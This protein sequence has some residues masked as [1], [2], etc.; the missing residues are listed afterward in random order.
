M[1]A[2]KTSRDWRT[3][4]DYLG[5]VKSGVHEDFQVSNVGEIG[6]PPPADN[7]DDDEI[8]SDDEEDERDEE[9]GESGDGKEGRRSRGTR[10]VI[11]FENDTYTETNEQQA[12]M[13][14]EPGQ[15]PRVV[16]ACA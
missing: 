7:N 16:D 3:S 6:N 2:R 12:T 13:R 15:L 10:V 14:T 5:W 9:K 1:S 11:E 4:Y 8:E